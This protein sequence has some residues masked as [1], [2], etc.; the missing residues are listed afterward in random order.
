MVDDPD[1]RPPPIEL[2]P[3]DGHA[4]FE[5][6]EAKRLA[7]LEKHQIDFR[8]VALVLKHP[9]RRYRS[10]RNGEERYVAVAEIEGRLFSLVYTERAGA[11]RIVTAFR[12][13]RAEERAYR[14]LLD[15]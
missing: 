8:R 3:A 6:D 14:A 1:R 10:E 4:E 5:W 15:R 11:C 12:S 9:H 2:Q 13:R 7:T